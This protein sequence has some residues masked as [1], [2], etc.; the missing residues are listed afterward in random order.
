MILQITVY[1]LAQYLEYLYIIEQARQSQGRS[2][3]I[4]F[5]EYF[6]YATRQFSFQK[7]HSNDY[8][9]PMGSWGYAFRVLEILGFVFGGLIAPLALRSKSYCDQ[10]QVYMKKKKLVL[11]PASVPFRKIKRKDTEGKQAYEK[12]MQTAFEHALEQLESLRASLEAGKLAGLMDFQKQYSPDSK[13]ISKLPVRIALSLDYCPICSKGIL[14]AKQVSGQGNQ[15]K[16]I[17]LGNSPFAASAV[18]EFLAVNK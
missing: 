7:E 6:D 16:T 13:A 1:F 4:A 3:D 18:K 2:I 12:E 9:D 15:V 10:C 11:L 14:V 5:F 8:G 17:D